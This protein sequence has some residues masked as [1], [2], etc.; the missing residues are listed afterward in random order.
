[1]SNIQR[2]KY[3]Q[4]NK[5]KKKI[6]SR[7]YSGLRKSVVMKNELAIKGESGGRREIEGGR[8][9]REG[10]RSEGGEEEMR[11]KRWERRGN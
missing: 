3:R 6:T 2:K 8:G 1:M 10:G 4:S 5:Y 11:R 7:K 9:E